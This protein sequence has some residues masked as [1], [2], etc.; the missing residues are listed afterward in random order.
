MARKK[1]RQSAGYMREIIALAVF[2]AGFWMLDGETFH[3]Q[4]E[5]GG[6]VGNFNVAGLLMMLGSGFFMCFAVV[7][8]V[9]FLPRLS[10]RHDPAEDIA[11][12]DAPANERHGQVHYQ[13]PRIP[14]AFSQDPH[15]QSMGPDGLDPVPQPEQY[16]DPADYADSA[17][18]HAAGG[19]AEPEANEEDDSAFHEELKTTLTDPFFSGDKTGDA[20]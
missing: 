7:E 6:D 11:S 14:R 1:Y 10:G 19:G 18:P 16:Y 2:A 5:S 12:P 13:G 8:R 9:F 4:L 15:Q 17:H 3:R 20:K